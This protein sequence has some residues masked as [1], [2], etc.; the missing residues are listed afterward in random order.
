MKIVMKKIMLL[1]KH[2]SFCRNKQNIIK[3][4][5]VC[6]VLIINLFILYLKYCLF[7]VYLLLSCF[8]CCIFCVR[9]RFDKYIYFFPFKLH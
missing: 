9:R 7:V 6:D 4:P 5:G 8:V 3:S 1:F 2:Y